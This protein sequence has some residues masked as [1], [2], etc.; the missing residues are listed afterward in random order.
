MKKLMQL[1]GRRKE[2][3]RDDTTAPNGLDVQP[4]RVQDVRLYGYTATN[5]W[6]DHP[7]PDP[8]HEMPYEWPTSCEQL[9]LDNSSEPK[10]PPTGL[11]PYTHYLASTPRNWLCDRCSGLQIGTH[12]EEKGEVAFGHVVGV[13]PSFLVPR[14]QLCQQFRKILNTA[15]DVGDIDETGSGFDLSREV[16]E[17]LDERGKHQSQY[18]S[19]HFKRSL[20]TLSLIP[21]QGSFSRYDGKSVHTNKLYTPG[22]V[23]K[24]LQPDY[25]MVKS[26][27]GACRERHKLACKPSPPERNILRVIDC[28]SRKIVFANE[29]QRYICLS[30]VWGRNSSEESD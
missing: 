9:L 13:T 6:P 26:W 4:A 11:S 25:G 27:L 3:T 21:T 17:L 20:R 14:C 1:R 23:I 15:L 10:I 16:L 28:M 19:I 8:P 22:T 7:E 2:N 18:L 5:F 29:G 12:M 30:Y 24:P